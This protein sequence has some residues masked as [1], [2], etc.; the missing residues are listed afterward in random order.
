[1][2]AK[3]LKALS[4]KTAAELSELKAK[5]NPAEDQ[6]LID[7]INDIFEKRAEA[8]AKSPKV[9]VRAKGPVTVDGVSFGKDQEGQITEK[10]YRA[11]SRHFEKIA[12]LLLCVSLL[13]LG[14]VQAQQI[15][16]T[17][18]SQTNTA[19]P[20]VLLDG[21][22]NASVATAV[23]TNYYIVIPNTAK[24]GDIYVNWAYKLSGSGTDTSIAHFSGSGDGSNY[25]ALA[26]ISIA[27]AGTAFVANGT[28]LT[29]NALPYVRL[30]YVTNASARTMSGITIKVTYKPSR[31]GT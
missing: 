10:Q 17:P 31:F 21:N 7:A 30:D 28:N 8:E 5:A 4:L 6:D 27:G 24:F 12:A 25:F 29:I 3:T 14:S 20:S 2:D 15:K 11:L 18:L 23:A 13:F 9:K 1:M 19:L 22:T 26:D 16:I